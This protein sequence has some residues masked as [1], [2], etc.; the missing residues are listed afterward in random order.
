MR[1]IDYFDKGAEANPDRVAIIDGNV[2]I[3]YRQAREITVKIASAMRAK[4]L[5]G[6]E[7]AGIL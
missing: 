6:E 4:G 3:P 2:R 7:H 5:N 1:A